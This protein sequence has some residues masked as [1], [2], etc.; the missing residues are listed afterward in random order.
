MAR[1]HFAFLLLAFCLL[2]G[3]ARAVKFGIQEGLTDIMPTKDGKH[4]LCYKTSTLC[5]F[6]GCHVRDDGYVLRPAGE[7]RKYIPLNDAAIRKLQDE[8]QLPTPL[9]AYSFSFVDYLFGYSILLVPVGLLFIFVVVHL[10]AYLTRLTDADLKAMLDYQRQRKALHL[11]SPLAFLDLTNSRITD[12]G[13]Q[14]LVDFP[15]IQSLKL[16]NTGVTDAAL[17]V[18]KR[19]TGLRY[20]ELG[21]TRVTDAAVHDLQVALPGCE[22]K[23]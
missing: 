7:P 19:L 20:L 13:L 2:P 16:R 6:L 14:G 21:G 3:Q 9:P 18:L 1:V 22:I 12:E 11:D 4:V 17:N 8:G 15:E 10:C 23:R 5:I